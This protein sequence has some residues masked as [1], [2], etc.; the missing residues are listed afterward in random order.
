MIKLNTKTSWVAALGLSLSLLAA[1]VAAEPAQLTPRQYERLAQLSDAFNEQLL[2][3][4]LEKG[5]DYYRRPRGN[6]QQRAFI[7]AFLA[8]ILAQAHQQQDDLEAAAAI[9][10]RSL[11]M[12]ELLDQETHQALLWMLV[13]VYV[14]QAEYQLALEQLEL[15]WTL[16]PE[17][18]AEA[19]YLRAAL[20]A[21]LERWSDAEPWIRSALDRS[22][23]PRASWLGL[24]VAVFQQQEKWSQAVAYQ[25]LRVEQ[26]PQVARLWIQLAQL[27]QLAGDL[28]EALV[29]QELAQRR[30]HLNLRQQER[31]ARALLHAEQPLRAAKVLEELLQAQQSQ[32]QDL[33]LDQL[34]LAAQA[35]MLTHKPQPTLL[36][37]QRLAKAS[38]KPEDWQRLGR[39]LFSQGQW[40]AALDAWGEYLSLPGAE[41][42]PQVHL[43]MANAY[44]ELGKL[45]QA[46]EKLQPLLESS[47]ATAAGQWLNYLEALN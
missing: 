5:Y 20:L 42:K 43:L 23:P 39:W 10:K 30:G 3:E 18:A 41:E 17:P 12:A 38:Q 13:Q 28:D 6:E 36:A 44:I 40:Q 31:L 46:R 27:Q 14:A 35:W 32:N 21:Q 16:E 34:A 9:L 24:A 19:E 29:T 11:Q 33:N 22:E 8:R 25:A 7:R 37:L 4:V 26:Q 15:W 45:E 47:Q 1:D 2:D